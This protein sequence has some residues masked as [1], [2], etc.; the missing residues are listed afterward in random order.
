MPKANVPT[1]PQMSDEQILTGVAGRLSVENV[2][3]SDKENEAQAENNVS[4]SAAA[5]CFKNC[6]SWMETQSNA[7][8]IQFMQIR[9]F[10][11]FAMCT[12]CSSLKQTNLLQ[13][14]RPDVDEY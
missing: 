5:E 12:R 14:F 11:D 8:P 3:S 2:E 4:N 1:T 9:R 10:M 13:R 6:L 7:D